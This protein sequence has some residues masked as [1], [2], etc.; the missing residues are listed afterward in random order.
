MSKIVSTL[1]DGVTNVKYSPL[2]INNFQTVY[3]L[4]ILLTSII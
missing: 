1:I 3:E 4:A 2:N